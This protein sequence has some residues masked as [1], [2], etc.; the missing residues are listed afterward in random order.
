MTFERPVIT[1]GSD[2]DEPVV[3]PEPSRLESWWDA[4]MHPAE[5]PA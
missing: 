2:N 5:P 1:R 3:W 4:V